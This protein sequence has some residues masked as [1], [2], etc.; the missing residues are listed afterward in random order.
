MDNSQAGSKV[1][2]F[3]AL[4]AAIQASG[5]FDSR[6]YRRQ[7]A[8][9]ALWP[10]ALLHYLLRGWRQGLNP[11][12]LFDGQFY[13][14]R[15]RDVRGSDANP[16]MHYVLHG[17]EEGRLATQSGAIFRESLHPELAPLP[18]F[19][20]PGTP[21]SRLTLVID[22]HTPHLLG[23]GYTPLLSL[24][25]H[26]AQAAGLS[27][28]VLVRS[29]SIRTHDVSEAINAGMPPK[30][31]LL[32]IA[33]RE[34]GHTDDVDT[35]EG[36]YWW[37]S[38]VSSFESLRTLVPSSQLR[39]V[40]TAD[41]ASRLPAGE[42]RRRAEA[43]LADPAT[44]TIVVAGAV[45]PAALSGPSLGI[46]ALPSTW[47]SSADT[48]P[49]GRLG[50]VVDSSSPE[51]LVARSVQVIDE[52]LATG[53]I[54]DD[55]S[56]VFIGLD[57]APIT[58]MGSSVVATQHPITDASEWAGALAGVE[59]ALIV[60]A[61]TEG[62]LLAGSVEAL[63]VGVVDVTPQSDPSANDLGA[64]VAALQ[65]PRASTH[66]TPSWA[67]IT[68]AVVG[69]HGG[70]R[71]SPGSYQVLDTMP[72]DTSL[73]QRL[74]QLR[75]GTLR[76]GYVYERAE[77]GTF[78][79]RCYNMV[80]ALNNHTD[81]I[82]AGY[83]FLYDLQSIDNLVDHLD[84]LVLVRVRYDNYVDRL[85]RQA[86]IKGIP[87]L[88]DLDDN[89]FDVEAT[90]LLV[91]SLQQGLSRYGR[92]E[93][94]VGVVGRIRESLELV[95]GIITT[96][97][98]LQGQ[99]TDT[100]DLPVWVVPNFLNHEQWDYSESLRVEHLQP[101]DDAPIIGYFSGS[102]S[103]NRDYQIA[104]DGLRAVLEHYPQARLRIAGYLDVPGSL[105][106]FSSRIDRLP[107][108]DFLGLQRA[109]AEVTL[110]LSPIQHNV[111]AHSKSELK[112]F[113]AAAVGVPT[114]AS[115]APVFTDTITHGDNGYL[116]D[117]AQWPEVLL[118]ALA[119]RSGRA[120]VAS[121]ALEHVEQDYT[122]HAVAPRIVS[123]LGQLG[124]L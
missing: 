115:P 25:A 110:N 16:L 30:R 93:K 40:L 72:W 57:Q 69:L 106:E 80:Q 55:T 124:S 77:P 79:Y 123:V 9:A 42:L 52:A 67:S 49:S 112:Y 84:V 65:A 38:S 59:R 87:V 26:T 102:A 7:S 10:S 111:F 23:L 92:I 37:A 2:N 5:L 105:A 86:R 117:A 36:E 11:S 94:W 60:R 4:R 47:D 88:Y 28:R 58:L 21:G 34:P 100:F 109:I 97:T 44:H 46:S 107:F 41:E 122:A 48:S 24:A 76:V 74:R 83:F 95:D 71:V 13:L 3:L 56:V 18:I 39:W 32:E 66:K 6:W 61:G 85:V 81:D 17:Q 90:P 82:S 45:D 53:G 73:V 89:I 75:P 101:A 78:R 29:T 50:V 108:M 98:F 121:R 8:E 63:G 27:L 68:K 116:A 114:V 20:V 99:L 19:A 33:R 12:P 14:A 51:S 91:S 35:L 113:E 54:D 31:P 43:A 119:E 64:V 104:A 1:G 62:A 22:D 15:Y 96:T 103:H 118:G 70:R 120:D